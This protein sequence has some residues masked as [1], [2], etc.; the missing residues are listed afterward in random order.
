MT[1]GEIRRELGLMPWHEHAAQAQKELRERLEGLVDADTLIS[2]RMRRTGRSERM[3]CS[4]LAAMSKGSSVVIRA[5]SG[6]M[7]DTLT[8]RAK[9]HARKLGL[10]VTLLSQVAA[11]VEFFDHTFYEMDGLELG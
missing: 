5:C 2:E 8:E 6:R 11:E 7:E 3:I 4:L 1:S 9:I 10:D